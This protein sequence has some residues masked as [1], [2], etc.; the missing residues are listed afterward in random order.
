MYE[1]HLFLVCLFVAIVLYMV[2]DT[3]FQVSG[4]VPS[5][6][7]GVIIGVIIAIGIRVFNAQKKKS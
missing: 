3:I 7:T 1:F 5:T 2:A 4:T 6:I